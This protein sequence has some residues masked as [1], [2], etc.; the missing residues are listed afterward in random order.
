LNIADI[1]IIHIAYVEVL[2]IIRRY[3]F[4]QA[5]VAAVMLACTLNDVAFVHTLAAVVAFVGVSDA[6]NNHVVPFPCWR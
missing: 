3:V 5:L 1:I 6:V 4:V 2:E